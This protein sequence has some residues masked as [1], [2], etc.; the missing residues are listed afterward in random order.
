MT[1]IEMDTMRAIVAFSKEY[2]RQNSFVE[3]TTIQKEYTL[4]G[5]VHSS[6]KKK[7]L[8]RISDISHIKESFD[9]KDVMI[10]YLNSGDR[11]FFISR[12]EYEK[13]QDKISVI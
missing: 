6:K 2:R 9:E 5:E 8:L 12:K 1:Q 13:L 10:V 4:I 3:L 7:V 11:K